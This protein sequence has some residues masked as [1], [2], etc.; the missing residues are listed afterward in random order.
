[1]RTKP[2]M[3]LTMF[4]NLLG[5]IGDYR[6]LRVLPVEGT[7]VGVPSGPTNQHTTRNLLSMALAFD[8]DGKAACRVHVG[9]GIVTSAF[10]PTQAEMSK[11]VYER[12]L[13]IT[14][15]P[16]GGNADGSDDV[17]CVHLIAALGCPE[18]ND[19]EIYFT[20]S[21]D[22]EPIIISTEWNNTDVV[23]VV[24]SDDYELTEDVHYSVGSDD[25]TILPA[26]ILYALNAGECIDLIITFDN[27]CPDTVITV[28]D[29]TSSPT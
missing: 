17:V 23:S 3:P 12:S 29:N 19:S 21:A 20:D 27:E 10:D 15:R 14:V 26:Y 2:I 25:F 9:Q 5:R 13:F 11:E 4:R 8:A 16:T 24:D 22:P 6:G 1:M 7:I 28:C 18:M